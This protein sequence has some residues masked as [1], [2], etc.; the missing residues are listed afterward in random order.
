MTKEM[1]CQLIVSADVEE[2]SKIDLEAF[3]SRE[4]EVRGREEPLIIRTI[5][6]SV[7]LPGAADPASG[8]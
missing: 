5:N 3:P 2:H 4:V 6:K 7:D 8:E 1:Q